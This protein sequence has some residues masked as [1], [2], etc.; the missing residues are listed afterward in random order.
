MKPR[1][2][3]FAAALAPLLAWAGNPEI[4]VNPQGL[5][6]QD[7]SIR[8]SSYAGTGLSINGVMLDIPWSP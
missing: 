1:P 8:G 3:I 6:Q 4:L 7:L 2:A 5:A